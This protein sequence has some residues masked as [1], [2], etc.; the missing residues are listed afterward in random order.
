L[1]RSLLLT[2]NT[3]KQYNFIKTW[4]ET[5]KL[6]RREKQED[7]RNTANQWR[8]ELQQLISGNSRELE[9]Q[10]RERRKPWTDAGE[11]LVSQKMKLQQLM[12]F[13][14]EFETLK[15]KG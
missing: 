4:I 3:Q 11:K 13:N 1:N 9:S 5:L 8:F 12:V 7:Y 2:N 15:L 10:S 14:F 6:K